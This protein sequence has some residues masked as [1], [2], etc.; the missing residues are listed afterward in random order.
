MLAVGSTCEIRV[1]IRV[2]RHRRLGTISWADRL[3]ILTFDACY[4]T[5]QTVCRLLLS[6]SE[7]WPLRRR[8]K[9]PAAG[10][11]DVCQLWSPTGVAARRLQSGLFNF[12]PYFFIFPLLGLGLRLGFSI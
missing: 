2:M 8:S 9:T 6:E 11:L 10:S 5:V 4:V 7:L 3:A 12:F 1:C